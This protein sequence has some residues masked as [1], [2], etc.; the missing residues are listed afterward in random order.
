M[1]GQPAEDPLLS[2]LL[3]RM[4]SL[5]SRI[6]ELGDAVK[7]LEGSVETSANLIKWVIFPLLMILAALVGLKLAL[8]VA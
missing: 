6:Q 1:S 2:L 4:D 8:P 5:E 7:T 3:K